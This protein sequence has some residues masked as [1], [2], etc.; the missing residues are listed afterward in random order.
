MVDEDRNEPE[1]EMA[2]SKDEQYEEIDPKDISRCV[3][4]GLMMMMKTGRCEGRQ[5]ILFEIFSSLK[6]LRVL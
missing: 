5:N 3:M 1:E 4:V 6:V 2:E